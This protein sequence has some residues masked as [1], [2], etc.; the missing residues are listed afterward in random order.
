MT[1]SYFYI[2][3]KKGE[4]MSKVKK[5]GCILINTKEKTVALVYREKKNGTK[6]Y[7]FPKGHLEAN[8]TLIECAVRE[9][10]EE[11]KRDCEILEKDPIY[12]EEY[13]TPDGEDVI[14]YYYLSKDIGKSDNPSEDT[15]K[16]FFI[17]YDEVYDKLSYPSLKK[18]WN[19]VKDKV[20]EYFE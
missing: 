2:I 4:I 14:L 19:L 1:L 11:T 17:P 13:V 3:I 8:E 7:S 12:I 20:K 10:A 18:V 6:D 15:H 9:T 5:A 16:T